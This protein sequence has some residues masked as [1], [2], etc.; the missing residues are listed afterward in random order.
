MEDFDAT[1]YW[2]DLFP[3]PSLHFWTGALAKTYDFALLLIFFTI[4]CN[5][6]EILLPVQLETQISNLSKHVNMCD[7]LRDLVPFVQFKKREKHPWKSVTFRKLQA[8]SQSRPYH[9]KFFK[10]CK[11]AALRKVTLLHG[12]FLRFFKLYKW[13]Q[14][15]QCISFKLKGGQSE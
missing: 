7:A 12:C 9:F 5:F 1:T 15:A 13:Y 2:F 4:K 14:I 11:P 10:A 6:I 3:L 8:Y